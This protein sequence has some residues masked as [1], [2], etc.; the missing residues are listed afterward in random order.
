MGAIF[1]INPPHF[2][3]LVQFYDFLLR[4]SISLQSNVM[5]KI[6]TSLVAQ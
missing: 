6:G 3:P 4:V 1:A 5:L 2:I